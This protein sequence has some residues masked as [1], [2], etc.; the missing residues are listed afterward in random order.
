MPLSKGDIIKIRQ[1][2]ASLNP[3]EQQKKVQ[4]ILSKLTP[5]EQQQLVGQQCPFCSIAQG[6]I[7]SNKVYEDN[8]V[9]AILDIN[10]ANPGHT[11]LFPKKH[12]YILSQLKDQEVS[13]LFK[14]AN[15]LSVIIFE[16][17]NA[18]G[19]NIFVAN[20]PAAGQN[21]QH[22]LIHIIPRFENDKIN[23]FWDPK[24][25]DEKILKE[26]AL[27]IREK[28]KD[29]IAQEEP[30]IIKKQASK[31]VYKEEPRIP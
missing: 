20:G 29:M 27:K 6:K 2:I 5:E 23:L 8:Q 28:A 11:I 17:L 1:E 25:V 30:Q 9:L 16:S 19:T 7:L 22:V 15:K 18:D 4:E 31:E 26:I 3:K 24:P 10:P 14:I 13:H 21:A 12:S